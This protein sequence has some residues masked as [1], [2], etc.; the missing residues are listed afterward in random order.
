[1][2]L[3]K[4]VLFLLLLTS[5]HIVYAAT[6]TN[7]TC[8]SNNNFYN[9][10]QKR[11]T[12]PSISM[13]KERKTY[14]A[15]LDTLSTKTP[16]H[17]QLTNSLQLSQ[18]TTP[19]AS[20]RT[21]DQILTIPS[22]CMPTDNS[23]RGEYK[24]EFQ[25]IPNSKPAQF[26]VKSAKH[27]NGSS[28]YNWALNPNKGALFLPNRTTF[29]SLAVTSNASG[30]AGVRELKFIIVD[31]NT[32]HPILYFINSKK[33]PL[34]YDFIRN[35]LKRYQNL[36]YDQGNTQFSAETYFREDRKHLAGSI[37]AYDNF[38]DPKNNQK[39]GLYTLEF[40]PTDPI[41]ARLIE[42]AY[43]SALAAMPFLPSPLA[44]HP[45]GVTHE[46]VL[47]SFAKQFAE[48]NIR[49]I[50]TDSIFAQLD[51]AILN[52]GETYG[53]LKIINPGDP[54]PSENIIAIY[55]YI[56]NALGHI[57]G[58]ITEQPQT[59]LS[60]INLKARQ[61]N[62]PNAYIKNAR[63]NPSI[64]PL[65]NQWVHYSV[66]DQGIQ[67]QS[68]TE[69]ESLKWLQ[70]KIP[71]HITIPESDLTVTEP[72]PLSSSGHIDWTHI[73]IKA[74]NTAE[75][76][77]ILSEGIY[78]QG[79]ALPFAMYDEF[80]RLPR[81]IN[82]LTSLCN[83]SNSVSFYDLIKQELNNPSFN[84]NPAIRKEYLSI[85]RKIIKKAEVPQS[86]INKI[87]SVRL[88]WEPKG[89][90]F[91]QKLRVRSST[92]TEDLEGFNGA[93]LY[94]SFTHKPKEGKLINSVKQVWASLWTERAF[95]ERR[96]YRI[97]HLKT[98]M[99]VLIHPSYGNEQA[100]GVAITKNI[101]NP[102]WEAF[103]IN[104]QYGELSITN[105]KPITTNNG[106]LTPI[107]DEFIISRLPASA[108]F[109]SWETLFIRHSNIKTVYGKPVATDNVLTPNEITYLRK[110]LQMVHGH[111]KQLYLGDKDFAMD[112]EFKISETKDGSRGQ[113]IIKQARPWVD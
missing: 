17:F 47:S 70:E 86:L 28:V 65:I 11:L 20:F 53:R 82:K 6:H 107:P 9:N 55:T 61:N 100:N 81:C 109:Y 110:N 51:S 105:P 19:T 18:S 21:N 48:K 40:W 73:G 39:R 85:L 16:F 58:I 67:I 29:D 42:K 23:G 13:D 22:L 99:G 35:D 59:A 24:V 111:F 64:S 57:A 27:Q 98:Y 37:V 102:E 33:T 94:D 79:Y 62:T 87:E 25:A 68:A 96:L 103:Y 84:Q 104:A 88:F 69:E 7:L 26:L 74:A 5:S 46:Q 76:R 106:Q 45:V 91:K 30:V 31:I 49:I 54:N 52:K 32:A 1:M 66:T 50:H 112:V 101:Y 93:G 60:H 2:N 44:Y 3:K 15:Q 83:S 78:P 38:T 71:T 8:S 92:N 4:K 43:Q 108:T 12:L 80:M 97:D 36:N 89:K 56:P 14:K 113:L 10:Q 72:Q 95:E 34:H 63:T 77:K 41:P 90:P 75:L